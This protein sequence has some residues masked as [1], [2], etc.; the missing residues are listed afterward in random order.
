LG[1]SRR[2]ERPDGRKSAPYPP[3]IAF[4]AL[5]GEP[6]HALIAASEAARRYGV[7]ADE[8]LLGEGLMHDEVFYALLARHVKAPFYRGEIPVADEVDAARAIASGIA[9]LSAN[10]LG[11]S[12]LLAPRGRSLALLLEA[13]QTRRFTAKIAVA[14]PRRFGACVRQA[15]ARRIAEASAFSL[16]R[17]D[18]S[19]SAEAGLSA[20]QIGAGALIGAIALVLWSANPAWLTAASGLGLWACFSASIGLRAA[21]V[22]A[23][24]RSRPA[25]PLR[26][27]HLPIYSIV[28]PLNREA[29]IIDR[30][31][32]ALDAIVYPRAKL[33]IKIVVEADDVETLKELA[34]RRLA[35]R[36]DVIVAAPGAPR[37]KPRALNVVLPFLRGQYVVVYDAEDS[38][39]PNQVLLAAAHFASEPAVGCLQARLVVDNVDDSWLTRLF[40][41]EYC[42]L[43][44]VI[45][46][47]L[48]ALGVPI[49]L[50][51]TSNHFRTDVLRRVGGWDAWNVTEDADLGLRLA[52]FG[53]RVGALDSD[54]YE[55]QPAT[56]RRWLDQRRRWQK[57][58]LQTAL[59]HSRSPLRLT[60]ELGRA[61]ALCAGA[62]VGGVVLGGL[63]GPPLTIWALWRVAFGDILAPRTLFE[64]IGALMAASLL[65]SGFVVVVGPAILGLRARKLARLGWAILLL[66]AYY[67]LVCVAAWL[68]LVD[69]SRRPHHWSKTEHGLAVTSIRARKRVAPRLDD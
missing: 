34:R 48:A 44:D 4:L 16:K 22:I 5:Y 11:L 56:L 25:E 69:Y 18:E 58:W 61:R 1:S 42:A 64:A 50:G 3:E 20:G 40:A 35:A 7:S 37:T 46:P 28:V 12:H 33:D 51:G 39:A 60:R 9:P 41:I 6:P 32:R 62:L 27:E 52:R 23:P 66:P 14:S 31:I 68:S 17:F 43:F 54:T 19:L 26:P 47:G 8:A 30:L 63:F 29:A 10:E 21:A 53:V 36:Y 59:V 65:L 49:A 55:E 45:N 38:P 67:C 15:S 57:G 24:D 13:A 2:A